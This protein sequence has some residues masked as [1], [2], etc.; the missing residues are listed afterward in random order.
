MRRKT[1]SL[2]VSRMWLAVGLL[3]GLGATDL[4]AQKAVDLPAEDRP[5]SGDF[6]LVFRVGSA[7]AESEWEQFTAIEHLAVRG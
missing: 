2:V 1:R 4:Q 5:I 6:E 7:G 3:A